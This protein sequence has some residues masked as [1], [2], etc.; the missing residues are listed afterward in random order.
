MN[1]LEGL[2]I[3]GIE[4]CSPDFVAPDNLGQTTLENRNIEG[5]GPQDS[6]RFVVNRDI[7]HHL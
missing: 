7:A 1:H 6:Y 2:P 3:C 5:A 4:G